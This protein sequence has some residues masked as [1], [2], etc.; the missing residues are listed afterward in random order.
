MCNHVKKWRVPVLLLPWWMWQSA[1]RCFPNGILFIAKTLIQWPFFISLQIFQPS[2]FC[3]SVCVFPSFALPL[4]TFFHFLLL[5]AHPVNSIFFRFSVFDIENICCAQCSLLTLLSFDT[6]RYREWMRQTT[7][8]TKLYIYNIH[9]GKQFIARQKSMC[10]NCEIPILSILYTA[11]WMLERYW[12]RVLRLKWTIVYVWSRG[13]QRKKVPNFCQNRNG[14]ATAVA[15]TLVP[16]AAAPV[17]W[18]S[19]KTILPVYSWFVSHFCC[20]TPMPAIESWSSHR[21]TWYQNVYYIAFV[22]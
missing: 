19:G 6:H 11:H 12:D 18:A 5:S 1:A 22:W 13:D 14:L 16:A 10:N 20:C 9:A 17:S 21:N 8:T 3:S 7:T 15:T 4:H 2:L